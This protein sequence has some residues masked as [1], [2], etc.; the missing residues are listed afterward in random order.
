MGMGDT[1]FVNGK[2][3]VHK[4]SSGKSA[5]CMVPQLCPPSPPAGPV[6]TPLPNIASAA[7]LDGAAKSVLTEDNPTGHA[8]SF[9]SKSMGDE[10][11]LPAPTFAAV[12]S[13]VKNGKAYYASHSMDVFFEGKAAITHADL[14]LHDCAMTPGSGPWPFLSNLDAADKLKCEGQPDQCKLTPYKDGCGKTKSEKRKMRKEGKG[15]EIKTPHHLL[16]DHCVQPVPPVP[17]K[18]AYAH[19]DAPCICAE[20]SSWNSVGPDSQPL[21]HNRYHRHFD[22]AEAKAVLAVKTPAQL[23]A[24]AAPGSIKEAGTWDY[25]DAKNAAAESCTQIDG[26]SKE[27]IEVQLKSYYENTCGLNDNTKLK[28]SI[29]RAEIRESARTSI[30][31][32]SANAMG[33]G[34]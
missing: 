20:G 11:S 3:V 2:A 13:H 23:A 8:D 32:D 33:A 1:V 5:G 27:C 31:G 19:A 9:I 28:C 29:E 16:P 15:H 22:V 12:I 26:C 21:K 7:D 24:P 18:Q 4:G 14:T 30:V 6:P 34:G 25:K 10:P 17:G